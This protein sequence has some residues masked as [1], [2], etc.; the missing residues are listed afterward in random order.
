MWGVWQ[1]KDSLARASPEKILPKNCRII[2]KRLRLEIIQASSYYI[3]EF[4]SKVKAKKC[5]SL[6]IPILFDCLLFSD[7]GCRIQLL[8]QSSQAVRITARKMN[9][10]NRLFNPHHFW[11]T[12]RPFVLCPTSFVVLHKS[13]LTYKKFRFPPW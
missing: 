1:S 8:I 2:V 12:K 6:F 11:T 5:Q 3:Y 10:N 9:K 13:R 4:Q 7:D